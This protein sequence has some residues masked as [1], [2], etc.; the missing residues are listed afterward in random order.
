ME[1]PSYSPNAG[2]LNHAG[3]FVDHDYDHDHHHEYMVPDMVRDMVPGRTPAAGLRRSHLQ[4]G[5]IFFEPP[6]LTTSRK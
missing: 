1:S 4:P 6:H 2:E 3:I 5:A